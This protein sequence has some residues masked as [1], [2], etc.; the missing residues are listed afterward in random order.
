MYAPD[1]STLTNAQGLAVDGQ[2]DT[3]TRLKMRLEHT[4]EGQC[5][6]NPLVHC[7]F[8]ACTKSED[9]AFGKYTPSGHM[10]FSVIPEIAAKLEVGRYYHVDLNV[11]PV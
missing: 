3:T 5:D 11:V 6:D 10:S 2:R 4:A 7:S 8:R 1:S 9:P